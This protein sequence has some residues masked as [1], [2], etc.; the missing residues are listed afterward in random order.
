M[1]L[2]D[3]NLYYVGGVVRDEILGTQ[4]FDTDFCYEGNAIE[5]A[6]KSGLNIIKTIKLLINNELLVPM[7]DK[8]IDKLSWLYQP[9]N[10]MHY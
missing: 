10:S 7:N 4:S 6:R 8:D 1:T 3:K 5:Y 2:K 9:L